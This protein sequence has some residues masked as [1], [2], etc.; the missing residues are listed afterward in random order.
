MYDI[1]IIGG[2]PAG[3]VAAITAARAGKQVVLIEKKELGGTCLNE[4][5]M[6]TKALLECADTYQHV[7]HAERFGIENAADHVQVNWAKINAYKQSIVQK[8]TGGVHYLMKRNQVQVIRGSAAFENERALLVETANGTSKIEAEKFIVTTGAEPIALPFAPFDGEWIMHSSHF[9]SLETP[10][11]VLVIVGGGVIGCEFASVYSRLGSQV[12]IAE[13]AEQLLPGEDPDIAAFLERSLKQQGV[14][15]HLSSSVEALDRT[16][17]TARIRTPEGT[18]EIKADA[19]LVAIGRKPRLDGLLLERAGVKATARGIEVNERMQTSQPHIFAAGDACGGIQ[20]AHVAFHEGEVAARNACG[21]EAMLNLRAVP[22]CI[23]TSP[24]VASVG[25]T[26]RQA[27]EKYAGLLVGEFPFSANGKA[28]ILQ[29][30]AGKVKVLVEPTYHEIVGITLVGARATELIGQ[31]ALMM[32]AEMTADA[33]EN[34]IAPHP[35]LSEILT[36]AV[37]GALGHAIHG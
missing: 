5:C 30:T 19:V 15:I 28:M 22:R 23:Y 10:P 20:L 3:Y 36:E 6:P 16:T 33:M 21:E 9:L 11:P 1:A 17:R 37:R 29:E 35:T 24:E 4:G 34:F 14:Q 32:H 18:A 8:L 13:M 2:G 27:R 7:L 26:E 25:L 12:V 31:A